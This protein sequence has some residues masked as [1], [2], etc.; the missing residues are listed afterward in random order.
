MITRLPISPAAR[1]SPANARPYN[2]RRH[3]AGPRP[4]VSSAP[5]RGNARSASGRSG[6]IEP[7]APGAAEVQAVEM[8]DLAVAAV[9]D[10]R[11]GEQGRGFAIARGAA[12]RP[13]TMRRTRCRGSTRAMHSASISA[14]DRNSSPPGSHAWQS[15][16]P[17]N[18]SMRPFADRVGQQ[19]VERLCPFERQDQR[20]GG[21]EMRADPDRV[22]ELGEIG[23]EPLG[24]GA[25]ERF[26]VRPPNRGRHA[27]TLRDGGTSSQPQ[28]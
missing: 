3:G 28:P 4:D 14:G 17:P 18:R 5:L 22:G 24:E 26:Q 11:R 25:G 13:R 1:S 12:G 8:G 19:V 15:R 21:V 10:R 23:C 16:S 27:A 20:E 7:P 9:A 6:A 2:R